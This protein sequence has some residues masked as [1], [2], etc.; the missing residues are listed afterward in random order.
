MNL[1]SQIG[2]VGLVVRIGGMRGT[3][4][5]YFTPGN[6]LKANLGVSGETCTHPG[7]VCVRHGLCGGKTD[8]HATT[9]GAHR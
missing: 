1:S 8:Q 4:G 7:R 3:I 2:R 5:R 9:G 6:Q